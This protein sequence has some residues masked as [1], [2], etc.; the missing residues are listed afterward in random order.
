MEALKKAGIVR[1]LG[2]SPLDPYGL[3]D[4]VKLAEFAARFRAMNAEGAFLTADNFDGL[5]STIVYHVST[6]V[7]LPLLLSYRD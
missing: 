3:D 7:R 6:I 1:D 5:F 4:P 2:R